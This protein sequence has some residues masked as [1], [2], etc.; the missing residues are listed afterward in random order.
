[1]SSQ[2][3]LIDTN[4]FIDLESDRKVNAEIAAFLA[5]ANKHGVGVFV[6][7]SAKDDIR[8]D[9]DKTRREIS[10]SKISKF[11]TIKK[12]RGLKDEHLSN[13]FGP[14][15]KDNDIV[16]AI[17]LHALETGAADFLITEDRKLHS[18]ARQYAPHLSRRV[19]FIADAASLL[20]S[21]YEPV[22]V[23]IRYVEEVTAHEIPLNDEIFDSLREGYEGFD[24]WWKEKCVAKHRKCWVV[25]D[26][27]LAGLIVR[28]DE[29][30]S[31]T[32]ATLAGKKILKI[33]TFKV[34]P[35]KRGLKIGE[36]LLR[37]A[38]WFAQSN[39]YD[40][41]YLT[42][43]IEQRALIELLEYY[44]F[45]HTTTQGED[46]L[47]YEKKMSSAAVPLETGDNLYEV[48]KREYP[49]FYVGEQVKSYVIP[50]KEEY[51][52][53]LFPELKDDP[54]GDLL[55]SAGI[56]GGPKRPGNTIRK[57]YLCQAQAN[58]LQPG[59]IIF[60]YKSSS[61]LKPSQAITTIGIF[62][63][64]QRATSTT[65]LMRLTGG[66]SV[67]SEAELKSW[68][69]TPA[70]PV[71]VINFLLTGYAVPPVP[72]KTLISEGIFASRPPQSIKTLEHSQ[73]RALLS[74]IDLG[75][76]T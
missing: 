66:R 34:R 3:Y 49:R 13:Q 11:Q 28:K 76:K 45:R 6:H 38:L 54:Q 56:T 20:V 9:Q 52:D 4:V 75:F 32:D 25:D 41:V 65:E 39:N 40:V 17:H 10:L 22:E 42:T 8:R 33:C 48:A 29:K 60:F 27:G 12:Q 31:D 18:R 68:N 55:A 43:K 24:T 61:T 57:V 2:N 15:N 46:E 44:G 16:D 47:V 23:P 71:K 59:A 5:L 67:Y 72:L 21:T 7:E 14:L 58:L 1:M 36:L 19:L 73:L 30:D 53:T 69:A 63:D 64:M 70:R 74:Q 35:E 62:E 51:H 50:I 37:Q 26:G